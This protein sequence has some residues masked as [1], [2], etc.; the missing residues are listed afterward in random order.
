MQGAKRRN[1]E[2]ASVQ[3]NYALL[4][5]SHALRLESELSDL[6][7]GNANLPRCRRIVVVYHLD[8]LG[9]ADSLLWA[10]RSVKKIINLFHLH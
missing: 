5:D 2:P 9:S 8:K 6:R 4:R 10:D 3:D 1:S 7:A